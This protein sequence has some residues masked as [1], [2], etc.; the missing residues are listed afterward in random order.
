[1]LAGAS[2]RWLVGAFAIALRDAPAR[3][4][5]RVCSCVSAMPTAAAVP[6]PLRRSGC[7]PKAARHL[8]PAVS[9]APPPAPPHPARHL[10]GQA[11]QRRPA[12]ARRRTAV[13]NSRRRA[14]AP[15]SAAARCAALPSAARW[16]AVRRCNLRC[17]IAAAAVERSP[18]PLLTSHMA[19]LATEHSATGPSAC[20]V[21]AY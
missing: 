19:A 11:F 8:L 3:S 16:W 9:L 21:R 14:A 10:L 13:A 7:A 17:P 6:D 1:M 15:R 5:L 2:C 4:S 20:L 12:E 18:V